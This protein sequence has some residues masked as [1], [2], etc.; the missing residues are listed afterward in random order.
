[1]GK[2]M[3]GQAHEEGT[4]PGMWSNGGADRAGSHGGIGGAGGNVGPGVV[5][6]TLAHSG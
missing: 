6:M 5:D 1:M 3:E 4:G 2:G